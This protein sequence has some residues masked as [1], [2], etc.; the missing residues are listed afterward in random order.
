[1]LP[2]PTLPI[3]HYLW[4]VR[5]VNLAGEVRCL[6]YTRMR[7]PTSQKMAEKVISNVSVDIFQEK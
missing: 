3:P 7:G 1:M 6:T 5:S 2:L 4:V